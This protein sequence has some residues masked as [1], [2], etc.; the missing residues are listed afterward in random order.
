MFIDKAKANVFDV[1]K[2][3]NWAIAKFMPFDLIDTKSNFLN[4]GYNERQQILNEKVNFISNGFIIP[5]KKFDSFEEG[6]N[7]CLN[8]ESEGLIFRNSVNWFKCKLLKEEKIQIVSHEVG[9]DKGTFILENG[10]RLSGT[11]LT[12]V[13]QYTDITNR[14]NKAI[15][16]IEFPFLTKEGKY[17]QPRLR[18]IVEVKK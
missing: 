3:E 1:S 4:L 11:S 17:F 2:R 10:S 6:W 9:K 14:G 7:Y 18:Q 5:M 16:E 13:E 15:A 8:N 12:Y